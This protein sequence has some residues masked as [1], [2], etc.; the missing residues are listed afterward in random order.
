M[1]ELD[2]RHFRIFLAMYAAKNVTRAAEAIGLSQSSVSIVLGQLR[3]HYG[4]PLFVRTSEG[5]LPTPRATLLQPVVRQA[6][7]LF[8]Q[9]QEKTG[10]FDPTQMTRSF[11]VCMT[12]VGQMT[13]L[14]PLLAKLHRLAPEIKIEVGTLSFQTSR[15]LESGEADMA[16][17]FTS[18]IN[19][20]FYQQKLF[21][22]GFVCIASKKHPRIG[23][24]M[25]LAHF[26]QEKHVD[27]LLSATSHAIVDRFLRKK[28][29]KRDF[30]VKVPSFLGLGQV[31]ASSDLIAIV[32]LRLG[33]IFAADGGVK[34]VSL[35]LKFP[36][37]T[38]NQYWHDRFH[39]DAGNVWLRSLVYETASNLPLPEVTT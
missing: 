14:P 15:E 24:K 29:V 7:Q 28:G 10:S 26:Q 36:T 31:V 35:P 38:V 12:D 2:L 39:R 5:M 9:G 11:R 22:E 19:A 1:N 25:T 4:D 17:G 13:L 3:E 16:S 8:E 20:G 33:A 30:A 32:P 27:I 18:H 23:S 37:Y 21:Q 34:V 6:L